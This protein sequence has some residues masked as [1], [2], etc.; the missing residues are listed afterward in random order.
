MAFAL[1]PVSYTHLDV[2]KRQLYSFPIPE[3]DCFQFSLLLSAYPHLFLTLIH[4]LPDEYIRTADYLETKEAAR[5]TRELLNLADVPTCI[6]YP[7]DTALIL[8]L[9]HIYWIVWSSLR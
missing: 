9:I 6:I 1:S 5:Q 7:D 2:Y 3:M 4:I 8:S